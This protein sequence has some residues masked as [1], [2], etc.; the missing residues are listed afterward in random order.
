MHGG[1]ALS[2]Y[3]DF[4]WPA[5]WRVTYLRS[6][7]AAAI[8]LTLLLATSSERCNRLLGWQLFKPLHRLAFV[9]P[10]FVFH[11]LLLSP[12]ASRWWTL[13]LLLAGSS[14]CCWSALR[15]SP[16]FDPAATLS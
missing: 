10:L 7:A 5:L 15:R 11:H 8:I 12:F 14:P 3:L 2:V 16:T 1:I 4:D 6:G 9:A 13:V